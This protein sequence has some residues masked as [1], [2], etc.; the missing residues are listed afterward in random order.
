VASAHPR[1]QTQWQASNLIGLTQNLLTSPT[2]ADYQC[3]NP[4]TGTILWHLT[5]LQ[6]LNAKSAYMHNIAN[7]KAKFVDRPTT[8]SDRWTLNA[9]LHWIMT[10]N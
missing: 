1:E 9:R 3:L 2:F 10:A 8:V 6:G 5:A 7:P 4:L